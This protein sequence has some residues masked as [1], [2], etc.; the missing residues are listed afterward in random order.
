M[1]R[2]FWPQR[3][4]MARKIPGARKVMIEDAGHAANLHQPAAFNRAIDLF[5][6][7]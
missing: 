5:S 2:T 6:R 4:N 1:T 3:I 7:A